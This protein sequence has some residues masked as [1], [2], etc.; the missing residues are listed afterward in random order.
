MLV[1]ETKD[2]I[3]PQLYWLLLTLDMIQNP[4]KSQFPHLYNTG[5]IIVPMVLDYGKD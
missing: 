4:D 1:L 5:V 2:G 3:T